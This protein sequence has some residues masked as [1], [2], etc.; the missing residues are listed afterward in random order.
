METIMHS[1]PLLAATAWIPVAQSFDG[2]HDWGGGWWL[3]MGAG[4]LIFLG[5]VIAGGVW[6]ARELSVRRPQQSSTPSALEVLD[7]RFADGA[8]SVE[9]YDERRRAILE[10]Q[11]ERR[12]ADG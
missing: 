11:R 7:H 4:M 12:S 8:I 6:L 1:P 5:L 10:A 3:L 2:H 9:E